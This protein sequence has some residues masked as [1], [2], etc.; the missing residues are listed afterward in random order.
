MVHS[1]ERFKTFIRPGTDVNDARKNTEVLFSIAAETKAQVDEWV[2]LA[3]KAG[4][5]ADPYVMEGN[6]ASMGMYVRSFGDLDGHIWEVVAV[7]GG[8]QGGCGVGEGKG[9]A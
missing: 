9:E 4:G 3:V 6:G 7:V 1:H 8:G 2:D 5:E